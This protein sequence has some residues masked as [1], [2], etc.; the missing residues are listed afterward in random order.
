VVGKPTN[1]PPMTITGPVDVIKQRFSYVAPMVS[2]AAFP[3]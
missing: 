1:V 3:I 2:K